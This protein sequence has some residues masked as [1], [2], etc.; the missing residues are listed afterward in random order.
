[1]RKG[2]GLKEATAADAVTVKPS[3][4]QS[5]DARELWTVYV[6]YAILKRLAMDKIFSECGLTAKYTDI[7]SAMVVARL[8]HP[9]S[10]LA[11]A[12]W[13]KQTALGELLN[14]DFDNL[15]EDILY[16]V[17]DALLKRKATIEA[18]LRNK[19]CGLFG[20]KEQIVLYD[21]TSTYF[22]GLLNKSAKAKRGYSRD[23]RAECK[24]V[25]VGLI[26]DENGFAKGHELYRGNK[27]DSEGIK[28]FLAT[29][30]A[31]LATEEKP[32]V[33]VDCGIAT[34]ENLEAIT[35]EGYKYIVA[36]RGNEREEWVKE[37]QFEEE[38]YQTK[39]LCPFESPSSDFKNGENEGFPLIMLS[40]K[41]Y[42]GS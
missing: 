36:V 23:G 42:I 26:L 3:A 13:I 18:A 35:A 8:A 5:S 33:V 40:R 22:E 6:G 27:S 19:E 25:V 29:L 17:S 38:D 14:R 12:S 30:G 16:R 9:D 28:E 2:K 24:Q 20:L 4:V 41:R 1:M 39:G 31:K 34:K 7:G 32:T 15:N 11:T 37:F 21:L 10:E